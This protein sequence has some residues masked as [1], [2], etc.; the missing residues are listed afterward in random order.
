MMTNGDRQERTGRTDIKC[1]GTV[2]R[3]P[4]SE[5]VWIEQSRDLFPSK[6]VEHLPACT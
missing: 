1:T 2:V 5:V 6:M 3:T 4:S